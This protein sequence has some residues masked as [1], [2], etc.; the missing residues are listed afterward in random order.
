MAQSNGSE[1]IWPRLGTLCAAAVREV[2]QMITLKLDYN[3]RDFARRNRPANWF[4]AFLQLLRNPI[5]LL[6]H[7]R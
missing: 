4:Y 6:R 2:A 1:A 7:Y 5:R 3:S